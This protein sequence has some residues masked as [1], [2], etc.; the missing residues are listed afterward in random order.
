MIEGSSLTRGETLFFLKEGLTVEGKPLKDFL[1][2][3]NHAEAIDW[4]YETIRENRPVTPGLVKKINALLLFGIKDTPA[5][6]ESGRKIRKPANSGKSKI[7]NEDRRKYLSALNQADDGDIRP[8][9]LFVADSLI[10]TE[11]TIVEQLRSL[12]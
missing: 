1:D 2:A 3:R 6:D 4:L 10:E 8:F 7:K 12:E 9:L 5:M 11:K